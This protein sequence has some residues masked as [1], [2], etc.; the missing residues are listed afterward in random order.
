MRHPCTP[1]SRAPSLS[2]RAQA[3]RHRSRRRWRIS[4]KRPPPRVVSA[5]RR[6]RCVP[7]LRARSCASYVA[8]TSLALVRSLSYYSLSP[9]TPRDR[10]RTQ[11]LAQAA[12][13][14]SAALADG[15]TSSDLASARQAGFASGALTLQP[16]LQPTVPEHAA[17][18]PEAAPT[19]PPGTPP[20]P[21]VQVV[22]RALFATTLR[23]IGSEASAA[24]VMKQPPVV[25]ELDRGGFDN[26]AD[27]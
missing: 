2:P 11:E 9:C 6:A 5:H 26:K 3:C 7:M 16:M 22:S 24:T 23:E 21:G 25:A 19:Q 8:Y 12:N 20:P 15:S 4:T 17:A 14:K 1:L 18:M 10:A 13:S 27:R